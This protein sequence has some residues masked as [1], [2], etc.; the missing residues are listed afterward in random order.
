[1][2]VVGGGDCVADQSGL[3]TQDV[4]A[5]LGGN[6]EGFLAAIG[7]PVSRDGAAWTYCATGLDGRPTAV[8]VVFDAAG[9]AVSANDSSAAVQDLLQPPAGLVHDGL[10]H[11]GHGHDGLGH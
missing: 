8:E 4:H 3:H 7:Q 5:L 6:A 11:D 9:T 10:G 2:G 1:V